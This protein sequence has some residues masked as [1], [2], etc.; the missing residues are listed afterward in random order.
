MEI[1]DIWI[2]QGPQKDQYDIA[3][4]NSPHI[5]AKIMDVVDT[6]RFISFCK[7]ILCTY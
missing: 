7:Y 4:L 3:K 2:E 5:V 1:P 6:I